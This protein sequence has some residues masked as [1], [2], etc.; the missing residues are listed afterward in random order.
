MTCFRWSSVSFDTVTDFTH[1]TTHLTQIRFSSLKSVRKAVC[2][3]GQTDTE[4][5]AH[6]L[7]T[8]RF[9]EVHVPV[10]TLSDWIKLWKPE[11]SISQIFQRL[12]G[13]VV[14]I[15]AGRHYIEENK[16][17]YR[18]HKEEDWTEIEG[19]KVTPPPAVC[20]T[21]DQRD[22]GRLDAM[23]L[24][25]CV[26]V[27]ALCFTTCLLARLTFNTWTGGHMMG[28]DLHSHLISCC[29]HRILIFAW[30]ILLENKSSWNTSSFLWCILSS[31]S[32]R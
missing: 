24:W 25:L 12:W 13:H 4:S 8:A 6:F 26:H 22:V 17:T 11:L 7:E 1:I 2:A 3:R 23:I 18:Q 28:F 5:W 9:G 14:I 30:S 31:L 10:K 19:E 29:F 21:T 32:V 16:Q 15:T 27:D 20:H